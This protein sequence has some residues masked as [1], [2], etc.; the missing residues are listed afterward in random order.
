MGARLIFKV[1]RGAT[2]PGSL[3]QA[4]TPWSASANGRFGAGWW[5]GWPRRPGR[6]GRTSPGRTSNKI[7]LAAT[8][9]PGL[10]GVTNGEKMGSH[11]YFRNRTTVA[12][13]PSRIKYN[14]LHEFVKFIL[15][16]DGLFVL[17]QACRQ[18]SMSKKGVMF[19]LALSRTISSL[20]TRRIKS[21]LQA[22]SKE[23]NQ[24]VRSCLAVSRLPKGKFIDAKYF[25]IY[26]ANFV[27]VYAWCLIDNWD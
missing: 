10:A 11:N 6:E 27:D 12:A 13:S 25:V 17:V 16:S 22:G 9:H 2:L 1:S 7:F 8:S 5:R 19:D 18:K 4:S 21:E 14:E 26:S 20:W 23:M 24:A 15:L 3:A